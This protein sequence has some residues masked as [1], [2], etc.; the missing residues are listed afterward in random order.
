MNRREKCQ[1][2]TIAT[3]L[4]RNDNATC[5][6]TERNLSKSFSLDFIFRI[7]TAYFIKWHSKNNTKRRIFV[8]V[9]FRRLSLTMFWYSNCF[10]MKMGEKK[11]TLKSANTKQL[12]LCFSIHYHSSSN[13]KLLLTNSLKFRWKRFQIPTNN[14]LFDVSNKIYESSGVSHSHWKYMLIRS[15]CDSSNLWILLINLEFGV[16]HSNEM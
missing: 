8:L 11:N 7:H 4:Q 16:S 5:L 1:Q 6:Y 12:E 14:D 15:L 3:T 13:M 9:F 10:D 2:V